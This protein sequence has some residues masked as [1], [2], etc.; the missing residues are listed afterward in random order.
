MAGLDWKLRRGQKTLMDGHFLTK[1]CFRQPSPAEFSDETAQEVGLA[2][3]DK[4]PISAPVTI[5]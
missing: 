3:P 1:R 2:T 4:L 5:V